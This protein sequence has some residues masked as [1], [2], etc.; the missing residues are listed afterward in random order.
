MI[1]QK[2]IL[3]NRAKFPDGLMSLKIPTTSIAKRVLEKSGLRIYAKSTSKRF[4]RA[5]RPKDTP[6]EPKMD[7]VHELSRKFYYKSSDQSCNML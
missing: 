7:A 4:E 6:S 5:W 2:S 1:L 3:K